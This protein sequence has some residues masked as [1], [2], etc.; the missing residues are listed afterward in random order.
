LCFGG[1][2]SGVWVLRLGFG[3]WGFGSG[4]EGLVFGRLG[5]GGLEFGGLV[6]GGLVVRDYGYQFPLVGETGVRF[7][8][9][10][11]GLRM[12]RVGFRV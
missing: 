9:W 8:V 7:A 4:F 11:L 1:L 10:Y 5:V 12:Y 2:G 3:V 6:V